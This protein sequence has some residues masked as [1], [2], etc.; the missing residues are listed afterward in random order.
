LAALRKLE[1]EVPAR[2]RVSPRPL[3]LSLVP[4]L[5]GVALLAVVVVSGGDPVFIAA[6][7]LTFLVLNVDTSRA[8]RLDPRVGHEMGWLLGRV[9]VPLLVL[10]WFASVDVVPW[11]G[12]PSDTHS[13]TNAAPPRFLM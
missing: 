7:I 11:F 9:G 3:A 8:Y 2:G 5:D 4:A 12:P 13:S 10:V 1:I 6:A